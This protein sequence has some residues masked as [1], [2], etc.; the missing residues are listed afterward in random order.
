MALTSLQRRPL[1]VFGDGILQHRVIQNWFS[2]YRDC[3]M[4]SNT[5]FLFLFP[6]LCSLFLK[7]EYEYSELNAK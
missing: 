7:V 3:I 2:I 6:I 5:Q 4:V 1:P